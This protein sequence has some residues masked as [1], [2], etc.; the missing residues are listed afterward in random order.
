ML[1]LTAILAMSTAL[2]AP[3]ASPAPSPSAQAYSTVTVTP[4]STTAMNSASAAA[5]KKHPT[6]ELP[7]WTRYLTVG[8]QQEAMRAELDREFNVDHS[9]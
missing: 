1:H 4:H 2:A 5:A 6:L 3:A 8:Q 7:A 9:P